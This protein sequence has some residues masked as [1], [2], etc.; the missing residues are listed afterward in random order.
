M[1]DFIENLRKN[2]QETIEINGD[3]LRESVDDTNDL[4]VTVLLEGLGYS[5]RTNRNVAKLR[6]SS[7]H[8]SI[9]FEE[10]KKV[11]IKVVPYESELTGVTIEEFMS[12]GIQG[13]DGLIVTD[14]TKLALFTDDNTTEPFKTIDIFSDDEDTINTLTRIS[15]AGNLIELLESGKAQDISDFIF[16]LKDANINIIAD[17]IVEQAMTKCKLTKDEVI[18]AFREKLFNSDIS[19]A[20]TDKDEA[21]EGYNNAELMAD[22]AQKDLEIS[23]KDL[24]IESLSNEVKR[25]NTEI[26][27][28]ESDIQNLNTQVNSLESQ[29][30]ELRPQEQDGQEAESDKAQLN[31]FIKQIEDLHIEMSKLNTQLSDKDNEIAEL[32]KKIENPVDEKLLASRELI[33]TIIDDPNGPRSYVGVINGNLFQSET[34]EKFV[35]LAVQELYGIVGMDLLDYLFD[36]DIFRITDNVSRKDLMI[37]N[38]IYDIE[39]K[40]YDSYEILSRLKSLFSK[41]PSVVFISKII[42]GNGENSEIDQNTAEGMPIIIENDSDEEIL[43][44]TTGENLEGNIEENFDNHDEKIDV[45][46][47]DK[48][49]DENDVNGD[50]DIPNIQDIETDNQS[51]FGD[52][53][54]NEEASIDLNKESSTNDTN[55]NKIFGFALCDIGNI[56]WDESFKVKKIK[57]L[58]GTYQ[59]F[60]IPDDV[61]E[62]QIL[63]LMNGIVMLSDNIS[64]TISSISKF[65]FSTISKFVVDEIGAD[66]G[67]QIPYTDKCLKCK[68]LKYALSI[69]EQLCNIGEVAT[70]SVFIY[71]EADDTENKYSDNI[72]DTSTWENGTSSNIDYT[73]E[74]EDTIHCIISGTILEQVYMQDESVYRAL[75]NLVKQCVAVRTRKLKYTMEPEKY[76]EDIAGLFTELMAS[77]DRPIDEVVEAIGKIPLSNK[78]I[79]TRD[80]RDIRSERV[81]IQLN[82]DNYYIGYLE[83]WELMIALIKIKAVDLDD[84][85]ISIRV[86]LN[87]EVLDFYSQSFYTTN[88]NTDAAIRSLVN[89]IATRVK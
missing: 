66:G 47:E 39:F 22:L 11:F 81:A 55:T 12:S 72:V 23:Q 19:T 53:T 35:G 26:S 51:E 38:K 52:N 69:L 79:I 27:K 31:D 30:N 3:F 84:K 64:A 18:E 48:S 46:I 85:A 76:M 67:I 73:A 40:D 83:P 25:L 71:V 58:S 88:P 21:D 34:I 15:S 43:T 61:E 60:E 82:G 68:E 37:N 36:G 86:V 4:L 54:P 62:K 14:G 44:D 1:Q 32:K 89:Y 2:L 7:L 56:L 50:T 29:L 41:F 20:E 9:Y 80:A 10:G 59:T 17:N 77:M 49:I 65:N 78:V 75:K 87:K 63:S 45:D 24:E 16:A 13:E 57:Y 42:G 33:D 8:W 70:D 28:R 6:N 74:S 5:R